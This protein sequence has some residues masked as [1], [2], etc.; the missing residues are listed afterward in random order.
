MFV[1]AAVLIHGLIGIR[2]ALARAGIGV[3]QQK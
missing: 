1:I 2:I 3:T